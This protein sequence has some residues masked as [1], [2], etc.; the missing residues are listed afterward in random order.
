MGVIPVNNSSDI[1]LE[2][3]WHY[4]RPLFWFEWGSSRQT[5]GLTHKEFWEIFSPNAGGKISSRGVI[6][7]HVHLYFFLNL[8]FFIINIF[9][10]FNGLHRE[11]L[12]FTVKGKNIFF[13]HEV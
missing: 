11:Y 10:A 9:K 1:P 7:V 12:V 8:Y 3:L 5:R 6:N 13:R 4:G 2:T